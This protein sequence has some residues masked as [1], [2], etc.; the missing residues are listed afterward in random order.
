MTPE[1]L[2]IPRY[3]VINVWPDMGYIG[4]GGFSMNEVFHPNAK[5]GNLY[6]NGCDVTKY[7]HLFKK[8]E[9]WERRELSEMPK[10]IKCVIDC[11]IPDGAVLISNWEYFGS[12]KV[13]SHVG[14]DTERNHSFWI[15]PNY[16]VPA[17]ESEYNTFI[18]SK[19]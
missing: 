10:Y 12:V 19:K 15:D 17:T 6:Y 11:R 2:M 1:E 7:P 5:H 3:K 4:E 9:W 16:F 8:L 14:F 13:I 18:E